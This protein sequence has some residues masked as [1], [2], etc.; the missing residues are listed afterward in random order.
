MLKPVLIGIFLLLLVSNGGL[1]AQ[2]SSLIDELSGVDVFHPPGEGDPA[3]LYNEWHYFNVI[4][5]E[6]NLLIVCAFKLNGAINAAEVLLGYSANAT[7]DSFFGIY[8]LVPGVVEYSSESPNVTISNSTVILTEE[9]YDVHIESDNGAKVFDALFIPEVEPTP[10]Y[11]VSGVPGPG[12]GISWL[13]A[14]TKMTVNG[15]LTVDG[16]TYTLDNKR[17]YHD[18]NWGYWSWGDDIGWDW[19][20]VTQLNSG[21]NETDVGEYSLSF[22]NITNAS[23]TQSEFSV[24]NVWEGENITASFSGDELKIEHHNLTYVNENV[25]VPYQG[26]VLP[27]G[28]FPLPL[29]TSISASNA[30]SPDSDSLEIGFNTE[31]S[32]PLPVVIMDGSGTVKYRVI[33]EIIG[34]YQVN[35]TIDGKPVS[36]TSDGFMEYVSGVPTSSVAS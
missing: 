34:T 12:M 13:V 19:G 32:V 11:N 14:S 10:V 27:P 7:P 15:T 26:V 1:A 35:G 22:G 6:Q 30:S 33:W 31:Q 21:S 23:H 17:G 28:S 5:E 16:Q 3:Y 20:Q 29:E 18:H 25:T 36:Y 4:D 24:L 2:N 9:G 8:P